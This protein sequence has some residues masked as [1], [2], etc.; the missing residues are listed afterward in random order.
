MLRA[1]CLIALS[2]ADRQDA[3]LDALDQGPD[4]MRGLLFD[5]ANTGNP[6]TLHPLAVLA[7]TAA[8][9]P[10]DAALAVLYTAVAELLT[11]DP[12]INKAADAVTQARTLA[13]D[14]ETQ[15][16]TQ[17]AALAARQPTVVQ[18]IIPMLTA[19]LP[20]GESDDGSG[21]GVAWHHG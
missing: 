15:W 6:D 17:L 21:G 3:A 9:T 12:D 19:P 2:S 5:T 16:I 4:R 7:H 18:H 13:P 8:T 11:T 20:E 1:Q 14:H 10:M